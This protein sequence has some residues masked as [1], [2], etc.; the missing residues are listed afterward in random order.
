MTETKHSDIFD[1]AMGEIAKIHPASLTWTNLLARI[2]QEIKARDVHPAQT[3]V[4]LPY[5]Q[6]IRQARRA[7]TAADPG[8][9]FV[10]RFETT[11]NWTRS[12][13]GFEPCGDDIRHDA[14]FDALTAQSLLAR[15]GFEKYQ[16]LL[17][18]RVMEAAWS[19][20]G[21]ASSIA[22]DQRAAWGAQMGTG[23]L[24]G[25][26]TPLLALEAAVSRIALAWAA[27]SSYATD[28]L[29]GTEPALLVI[30]E[31]FQVEPLGRRLQQHLG[32]R[33]ISMR[34]YPADQQ[35][36]PAGDTT[37]SI[38]LHC[39]DDFETEAERAAACVMAHLEGGRSPVALVA[40]DRLLTRRVRALLGERGISIRDET[41]WKLST[42]RAAAT[43]MGMLRACTWDASS[44]AVLDWLKNSPA[45]DSGEV[46]TIERA[47]R[48]RGQREW[49]VSAAMASELTP[50]GQSVVAQIQSLREALQPARDLSHWLRD[51]R[52]A[53]QA[54]GQWAGLLADDAGR[55]VVAALRLTEGQEAAF[56]AF[57]HRLDASQLINWASQT[58]EAANYSP[59]HP[60]SEQ[61]V[62]LPLSQLLG[63][64]LPA[65][66]LPGC[67]E[68]RFA[69]SPEPPGPWTPAM[70]ASLGLPSRDE[71]ALALR[72]SWQNALCS[73]HL[74]VLW[75]SSEAG[76]RLMPSGFVQEILI[77]GHALADDPRALRGLVAA[78]G[79]VP[80]PQASA[81]ALTRLS[82][83][84]YEDL[85]RCPYRFFALRQLKLSEDEEIDVDIG[86]R[87]FGNWLHKLLFHFHMELKEAADLDNS[88]P[89]AMINR[90][91]EQATQELGL[92]QAEFL[93]FSAAWPAVRAG[94]L[95]WLD[96][97]Q[98][99]GAAFREGEAWKEVSLGALTLVGK[100]DRVDTLADG[101]AMVI[102]YKTENAMA[103]AERTKAGAEDTQLA[104]YAALVSDDTL[105]AAYLNVGEKSATRAFARKDI[106]ELRDHLI[107]G[108]QHDMSRIA[109]GAGLTALGEGKACEFCAARGLCRK[110][111]WS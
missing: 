52:T 12:L 9:Q 109:E 104:F 88:E 36:G 71:L 86:K 108:I 24:A 82:A 3:V 68:V 67:D 80:S 33:C 49:L 76:E 2:R 79:Q 35:P 14:A 1:A 75:R 70:R 100:L 25:M 58:L 43:L 94:Y 31:G 15:A 38:V 54:S 50:A 90:A 46:N 66:V 48:K 78:P 84:A 45:F 64:P 92:S 85:R 102:D 62:I 60:A 56:S 111:F 95:K 53:L 29:F 83:S 30:L 65:A 51:V 55:G 74:D 32:V 5:A 26:D 63:R 40:L 18:S 11:Q 107:E 101:S 96:G 61:V 13:A 41:G 93:P 91:S 106:V 103:S 97:H 59:K 39:A 19:L 73:P 4:L 110:D 57:T 37:G 69:V 44:D 8:A 47:L 22:P 81:V 89:V 7:W 34:L 21:V 42:T 99:S 28:R 6:L 105:S 87:D 98:A 23:L 16:N 20:A 77:H 27:H 72:Q 10:P 17:G